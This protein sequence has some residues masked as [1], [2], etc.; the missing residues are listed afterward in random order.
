MSNEPTTQTVTPYL[1]VDGATRFL[2]FARQVFD[3]AVEREHRRPENETLIMH[4]QLRIGNSVIMCADAV[5]EWKA[6]AAGL[7][8]YVPDADNSFEKAQQA[9]ATVVMPL[10]DQDYGR[11]CGVKDPAGVTWWITA[12]QV[13]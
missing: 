2:D 5:D 1:I 4:A 11:T 8:I 10:S 12:Q 9:G 7:F 3:A 13:Q 6:E